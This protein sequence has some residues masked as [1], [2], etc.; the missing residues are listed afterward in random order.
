MFE[1]LQKHTCSHPIWPHIPLNVF[2]DLHY[3]LSDFNVLLD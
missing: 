2:C 1:Q 3:H